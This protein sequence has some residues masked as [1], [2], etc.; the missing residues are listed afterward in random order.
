MPWRCLGGEEVWLLLIHD[1]GTRWGEWSASRPGRALLPGK[2]HPVPI[3]QEVWVGLRA[4]LD[5]EHRGKILCP[6]RGS[7]P[8]RPVAH[9]VVRHYTDWATR[10]L[11]TWV[12]LTKSS[13]TCILSPF[14]HTNSSINTWISFSLWNQVSQPYKHEDTR[15]RPPVCY[16]GK[17]VGSQL[18][19][20][21][22]LLCI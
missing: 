15:H 8:D 1:L 2:G 21:E 4:G 22:L 14:S 20:L 3:G 16:T 9:P 12:V 10:L 6:C 5:T 13:H 17:T 11:L 19:G 7:K 18:S